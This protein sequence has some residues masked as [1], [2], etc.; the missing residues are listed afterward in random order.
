MQLP[1]DDTDWELCR[2][3][4]ILR[5]GD[6]TTTKF[7]HDKWLNSDARRKRLRQAYTRLCASRTWKTT[8]G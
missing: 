7:G 6:G 2:A 8:A 5:I 3:S 4:T 1:C